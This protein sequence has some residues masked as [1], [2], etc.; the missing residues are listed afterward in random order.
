MGYYV[1]FSASQPT[2]AVQSGDSSHL[3]AANLGHRSC[4]VTE[5]HYAL[6]QLEAAMRLPYK[7]FRI[8]MQIFFTRLRYCAA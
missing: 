6:Q 3:V 2:L 5:R 7:S 4:Q 8:D 1:R